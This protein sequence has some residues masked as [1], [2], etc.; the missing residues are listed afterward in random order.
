MIKN[1]VNFLET[2]YKTHAFFKKM[3]IMKNRS[4]KKMKKGD[5]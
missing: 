4:Q 1:I 5:A 2:F 3:C